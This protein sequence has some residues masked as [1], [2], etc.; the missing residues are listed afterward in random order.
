KSAIIEGLA[1]RI[2]AGDIPETLRGKRVVT[3]DLSGMLA[4]TK[5]RGDFEERIKA[6]LDE[7]KAAGNTVLFI[8][9]L[10]TIVGAGATT[11][12]SMD[13]SNILKPALARGEIQVVGA[14]TIDEY[15]KYI[16]KD[17]AL[18][19]RFQP[20][21]VGEPTIEEAKQILFGLRDRYEAHH[22]ARIT[23]E[24]IN[25]A[26]ELSDR[27]ISDRYLPDK[28]I[29]LM[30]EAASK[31]RLSAYVSPPDMKELEG[32]IEAARKEKEE[33][34]TNQNYERAALVRDE[35]QKL[36]KEME[37]R[38]SEW[39]NGRK[40][41]ECVVTEEDVASVVGSWT[42]IPVSKLTQSE[43]EKLL[44]ME[45]TLHNRVIGQEEAVSAV[46][47]AIRRA[48]AG[49]KDPKRPIGSYI[50]LGPTGVGKTEL[51]RALAEAMF[52]DENAMIRLD[53]SEYMEMH[54]VAKLTGAPPGYVGYDEGGQ[55]TEK[56]RKKPYAV[57]LFDEIEKAH[58]DV[59]NVLLQILE[60][61]RLTDSKGRMVDFKNSILIMT[62]NV[63][64]SQL[65][66][67]KTMGFGA[68]D[69]QERTLS[70]ERMKET[71]MGELKKTFRPEFLNRVDEI[72]LFH[73]LEKEQTQAIVKLMLAS[74]VNR[75][76][77]RGIE[78]SVS[79]EAELFLADAGFDPTYGA[80]PL[81]RAIQHQ[82]EDTLSEEIL[83]GR[84]SLGDRVEATVE[85]GKLKF[86]ATNKQP[87]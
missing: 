44:H 17:A 22:K 47:R 51:T 11:E 4:G 7:L 23:D 12:G 26:V 6:A 81:R 37:T 83:A 48:R 18:E 72:I 76:S 74:V 66:K 49:L 10:H 1:Q 42:G 57:I 62:S 61:G 29:D 28:A 15:R 52:G 41:N 19:R 3:L 80:R 77:E 67:Q 55:L 16:E 84:I 27:Y 65:S 75:L 54:S 85:N 56:V 87:L 70:Y 50:F 71:M 40:N 8:D 58:P 35:E 53:M 5:Y 21:T 64:A 78:L 24:A 82:V 79:P 38:R 63:G 45:D 34:V 39:E 2:V 13:A 69:G 14:T 60:D 59:F 25:A 32:K 31:V 73:T 43:S 9:E 36:R 30:D 68:E 86:V 33:A 20:V 46:S